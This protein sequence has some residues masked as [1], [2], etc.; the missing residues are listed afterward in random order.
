MV[1]LR[2][3]VDDGRKYHKTQSGWIMMS[4]DCMH[5]RTSTWATCSGSAASL[6]RPSAATATSSTRRPGTGERC[7]T[8]PSRSRVLAATPKRTA[9]CALLSRPPVRSKVTHNVMLAMQNI[10]SSFQLSMPLRC[11]CLPQPELRRAPRAARFIQ[12]IRCMPLSRRELR[13]LY[14]DKAYLMLVQAR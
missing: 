6:R 9:H 13:A 8:S 3:R 11:S 7:S 2:F 1:A 5:R 14:P 12:G 10:T 4:G